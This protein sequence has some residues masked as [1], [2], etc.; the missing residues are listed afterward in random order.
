[1]ASA[2]TIEVTTT[3]DG[4]AGSLRAAIES[5]QATSEIDTI[6]FALEGT[7]PFTIAPTSSLPVITYPLIIDGFSQANDGSVTVV[8]SGQLYPQGVGLLSSART[9][10][11]RG[12]SIVNWKTGILSS[13]EA[14]G[15]V[16]IHGNLIGLK[17]DSTPAGNR[18]GIA[19]L[20]NQSPMEI[21][22]IAVGEANTISAN[23][24]DGILI[25]RD[26]CPAAALEILGNRIGTD[27]SGDGERP[28]GGHGIYVQENSVL[29]PF[30]ISVG[31]GSDEGAN[32]IAFNGGAGVAVE[33]TQSR[34]QVLNNSIHSNRGLAIDLLSP[35]EGI[36]ENDAPAEK[37]AD[38]EGG[39]ELQNFPI[40]SAA[41]IDGPGSTSVH[42]ELDSLGG[43]EFTIEIYVNSSPDTMPDLLHGFHGEAEQLALSFDVTTNEDGNWGDDVLV[44]GEGPFLSATATHKPTGNTS[45]LSPF[46]PVYAIVSEPD[47]CTEEAIGQAITACEAKGP[48]EFCR[49]RFPFDCL[50]PILLGDPPTLSA[51][52]VFDGGTPSGRIHLSCPICFG[53]LGLVGDGIVVRNLDVSPDPTFSD[54]FFLN[55]NDLLVVDVT[56]HNCDKGFTI[57]Q[58]SDVGI[59]FSELPC[60]FGGADAAFSRRVN[61]IGNHL[62]GDFGNAWFNTAY[63]LAVRNICESPSCF[64]VADS[65]PRSAGGDFPTRSIGIEIR[66]NDIESGEGLG[67]DLDPQGPTA[68]DAGDTDDGANRLQNYP[69]IVSAQVVGD[70]LRVTA[71]L[72]SEPEREYE[73]DLMADDACAANGRGSG[74]FF[75]T[76][77]L[78]TDGSG[79]GS[80]LARFD[81]PLA[82]IASF[83]YVTGIATSEERNSS[84]TGTCTAV[85]ELAVDI[86]AD[87]F[88]SGDLTAWSVSAP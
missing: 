83:A 62:V 10:S 57:H 14:G 88:E 56:V 66:Q 87:G 74:K 64:P 17:P 44:P 50:D 3:A 68:N 23:K 54:A 33:Q 5:A 39:N 37:D 7:P 19:V 80:T 30:L 61:V 69:E 41:S 26:A 58:S 21:G 27:V 22:G 2:G 36:S 24:A 38:T 49:I 67:I 25:L 31:D 28:N 43:Q 13:S 72:D 76:V 84:E 18:Y 1:V 52:T 59:G 12:L 60:F 82:G 77:V 32:L 75:G 51:G 47:A 45:E 86:F 20:C 29:A 16:E 15:A 42:V 65:D 35:A 46:E 53:V 85:V 70:E 63:G 73:V 9:L 34:V 79:H 4:G 8:L 81:L 78:A 71:E 48:G 11:V 55:G 6:V 40:L